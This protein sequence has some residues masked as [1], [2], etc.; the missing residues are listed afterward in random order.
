MEHDSHGMIRITRYVRDLS[1][2]SKDPH[3]EITMLCES[4]TTALLDGG[5]ILGVL[6]V[7]QALEHAMEKARHR[8]VGLVAIR[9]THHTG[10]IEQYVVEAAKAEFTS[11]SGAVLTDDL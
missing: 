8:D 7:R 5:G 3:A 4:T 10:R 6:G 9:S 11:A 1:N 2:G